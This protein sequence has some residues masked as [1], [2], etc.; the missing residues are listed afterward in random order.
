MGYG[1]SRAPLAV[2][3]RGT[4]PG[5]CRRAPQRQTPIAVPRGGKT[6]FFFIFKI[7]LTF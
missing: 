2:G 4:V 5:P 1:G 6:I 7:L 3:L